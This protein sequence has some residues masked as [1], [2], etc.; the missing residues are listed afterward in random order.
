MSVLPDAEQ[1]A[2]TTERPNGQNGQPVQ[3]ARTIAR[4][5]LITQPAVDVYKTDKHFLVLVDLP[6]LRNVDHI[7]VYMQGGQLHISGTIDQS[8]SKEQTVHSERFSGD[9]K[10]AIPIPEQIDDEKIG[11]RYVNGVLE[12][13]LPRVRQQQASKKR[14]KVQREPNP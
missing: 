11:A 9:F 4:S 14:I 7:D 8:F 10:R 2:Q 13:R 6:G 3:P 1:T 12:I 5:N